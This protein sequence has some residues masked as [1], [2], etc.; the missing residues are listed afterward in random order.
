MIIGI[1][2]GNWTVDGMIIINIIIFGFILDSIC[3][4]CSNYSILSVIIHNNLLSLS[5]L[6]DELMLVSTYYWVVDELLES[7][8]QY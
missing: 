8:K 6:H 4:I 7:I 3:G 2:D 1:V 5:I